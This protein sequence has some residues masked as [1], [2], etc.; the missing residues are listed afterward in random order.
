MSMTIP[1]SRASVIVAPR[2]VG[3]SL[4][5]MLVTIRVPRPGM[6]NMVSVMTAPPS[7]PP[8]EVAVVVTMDSRAFF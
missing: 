8:K 2:T 5:R 1:N 6:E 4:C 7:R 3:V